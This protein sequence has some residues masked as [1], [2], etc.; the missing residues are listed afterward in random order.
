LQYLEENG[1][2][3]KTFNNLKDKLSYKDSD[4]QFKMPSEFKMTLVQLDLKQA[5]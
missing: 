3:I 2:Q 1:I 4:N 5:S